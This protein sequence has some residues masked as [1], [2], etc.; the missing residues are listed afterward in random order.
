MLPLVYLLHRH[1]QT[2]LDLI[3]P[4]YSSQVLTKQA[5]QK[6]HHDRRA[7]EREFFVG[8]PV[9]ARNMRPGPDWVPAV[10][11]ERLGPLTYLVETTDH[12]LW[13]RHI[14]LFRELKVN[15]QVETPQSTESDP[16]DLDIPLGDTTSIG[17]PPEK[18]LLHLSPLVRIGT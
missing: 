6:V 2:R 12:L 3:R 13:K 9:M 14:D 15:S 18:S 8:Q 17:V 10:V 11:I 5:Q 4:D 16:S 1:I 7:Q